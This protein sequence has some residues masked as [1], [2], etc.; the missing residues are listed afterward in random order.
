MS[1]QRLHVAQMSPIKLGLNPTYCLGGKA[2]N[3]IQDS[4]QGISERS[5]FSN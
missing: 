3:T 4:C 1:T 5:Y 2:V